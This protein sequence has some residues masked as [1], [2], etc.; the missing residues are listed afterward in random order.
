MVMRTMSYGDVYQLYAFVSKLDQES[1]YISGSVTRH[2]HHY[3]HE[4]TTDFETEI[5]FRGATK[6]G[7]E[8]T[9]EEHNM[10]DTLVNKAVEDIQNLVVRIN[11]AIYKSLEK[12]YEWQTADEQID[13]MIRSNEYEFDE[14]GDWDQG[15]EFHFDD[16]QP[17]AKEKARNWAREGLFGSDWYNLVIEDWQQFLSD[18]GFDDSEI[19]FSGFSSQGDGASFTCK[20]FDL[21]KFV[22]FLSNPE[23]MQRIE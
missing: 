19:A 4:K 17:V 6:N 15:G 16:L 13:E 12:E 21:T 1:L 8:L 23:L 11:K 5:D 14:D 7:E 2:N 20:S 10:G 3:V 22:Q 18:I 9:P